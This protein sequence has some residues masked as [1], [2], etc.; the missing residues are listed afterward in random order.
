MTL[1]TGRPPQN[2]RCADKMCIKRARTAQALY[3]RR[4]QL[5]RN[6]CNISKTGF[7]EPT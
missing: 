6:V 2:V 4:A 3:T 5:L 7:L 1:E